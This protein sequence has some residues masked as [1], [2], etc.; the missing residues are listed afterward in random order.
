MPFPLQASF[1]G[2]EVSP[3]LHGRVDLARYHVGVKTMLN[4][5]CHAAGGVSNRPGT[6]FIGEV[7]DSTKVH[8]L[9]TFVFSVEQ[10]YCLVF[11][12]ATM[13][14]I[15]DGGFVMDG[16]SPYTLVT[17]YSSED[18]AGLQFTQSA[19][20][21]YV[22]H[23]DYFPR[24]I[25]RTAHD[26]WNINSLSFSGPW[27][28][29]LNMVG[30]MLLPE[31]SAIGGANEDVD[32]ECT[33]SFFTSGM[34][35]SELR[36]GYVNPM[37][38]F[39]IQW[40]KATIDQY[41]STTQVRVDVLEGGLFGFVYNYNPC[42]FNK[43]WFWKDASTGG[44]SVDIVEGLATLNNGSGGTAILQQNYI[45]VVAD[46]TIV[47]RINVVTWAVGGVPTATF[48]IGTQA[49]LSDIASGSAGVGTLVFTP[50]VS[51]IC[52]TLEYT[53]TTN[54]IDLEVKKL[55]VNDQFV[56]V[57][58]I[59]WYISTC[60]RT[61]LYPVSP[62]FFEQR[63][64]MGGSNEKPQTICHSR[65]GD[66]ENFDFETPIVDD[67]SFSYI[68]AAK[69]VNNIRWMVPLKELIVGTEGAI[70]RVARGEQTSVMT[71]S[72]IDVKLQANYGCA[73]I[74]P[75]AIGDSVL[76]IQRGATK[77]RNL[78]Y[79]LESDGYT[80]DDLTVFAEHIFENKTIVDWAYAR[81]PDSILWCVL[82]DG[83][84]A[85]MTFNP[86]H[87][88]FGWHRHETDGE[89]E[90]VTVVPGDTTDDVYFVVKR[91][92]DSAYVRYVEQLMP[93]ITDEDEY[94]Y[95]FVDCGLTY[96]STPATTI[97]GL[98][99]LEGETVVALADGSVVEDLVV[100]SGE[101]TLP[102]AASLVHVG[103]TYN[104]DLA[105]LD[106]DLSGDQGSTMGLTKIISKVVLRLYKT[107]Y[108]ECGANE[109]SLY[110][111]PLMDEAYGENPPALFTGV[112]E[113]EIEA[114]YDL[115]GS[116]FFRNTYPVPVT[117]LGIVPVVQVTDDE[118]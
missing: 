29:P 82:S 116:L 14:V 54:D 62:A 49:G 104:M 22:T 115:Y 56:E 30:E 12:D 20:T 37:D 95:F 107:R 102:T 67:D 48:K 39:T 33:A 74:E 60:D 80:G 27:E 26:A 3:S 55:W 64:V 4:F 52:I 75:I 31:T 105:P 108:L 78:R 76:F 83:T 94:D 16:A 24:K 19:D 9:V 2:G 59:N 1:T 118:G 117:I 81:M 73:P 7:E 70:W 35:G 101:I 113:V 41:T 13:Q 98:D 114:N 112:K 69:E 5:F 88:V 45:P 46:R 44:G 42:F 50:S 57:E 58:T 34:V 32:I 38:S 63:F 11:G 89:F 23:P 40:K 99:H 18:L 25:T 47:I 53:N 61:D 111:V 17:P 79:S 6:Y 93:R 10:A 110:P 15:M 43:W 109:D 103:L 71:P 90:S 86:E 28:L 72:S 21:L 65:T 106:L 8:R 36:F 97:T 87:K 100:S 85:G 77:I 51:A 92:I 84:L 91:Y 66:Y 68:I 96:D